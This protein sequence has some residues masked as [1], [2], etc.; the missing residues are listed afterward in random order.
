[1][2][3]LVFSWAKFSFQ[4]SVEQLH[5]I[6]LVFHLLSLHKYMRQ[7]SKDLLDRYLD[8]CS[9]SIVLNLKEV[10]LVSTISYL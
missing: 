9:F 3:K 6:G 4:Y 10:D 2:P 5:N 8:S 7:N 1:M